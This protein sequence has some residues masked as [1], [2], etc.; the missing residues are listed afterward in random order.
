MMSW[1][2]DLSLGTYP[3]IPHVG[4]GRGTGSN[5]STC[6]LVL[7]HLSALYLIVSP[8]VPDIPEGGDSQFQ[9]EETF[10]IISSNSHFADKENRAQKI[11][12][13][14]IILLIKWRM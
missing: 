9:L 4:W 1:Q 8:T 12:L 11:H 3:H 13:L 14:E 7:Y 6:R 2:D 10:K 5:Q